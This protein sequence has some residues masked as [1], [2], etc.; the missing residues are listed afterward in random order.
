MIQ[1]NATT[2]TQVLYNSGE[3]RLVTD[4]PTFIR[5]FS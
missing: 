5:I 3:D 1:I 4:E 2:D